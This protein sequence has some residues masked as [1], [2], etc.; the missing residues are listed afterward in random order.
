MIITP[1][2]NSIKSKLLNSDKLLFICGLS[3]L[4][5]LIVFQYIFV[6]S[7]ISDN[8]IV[9]HETQI[10]FMNN[11][12]VPTL[13]MYIFGALI[14]ICGVSSIFY[15]WKKN[16][17]YS[18]KTAN[19]ICNIYYTLKA[20]ISVTL[21]D[22]HSKKILILFSVCYFL[23]SLFLNNTIIVQPT[24]SSQN[25]ETM[26]HPFLSIIGCCG[27]P[28][29]FPIIIVHLTEKIGFNII[30]LNI[31]IPLLYSILLSITIATTISYRHLKKLR[32]TDKNN[33]SKI[34]STSGIGIISGF[35]MSCPTCAA[36]VI[37]SSILGTG[38]LTSLSILFYNYQLVLLICNFSL[39]IGLLYFLTRR[40]YILLIDNDLK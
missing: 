24:L 28:G 35:F 14:M 15:R 31:I 6:S 13:F 22:V 4:V 18:D 12:A 23:I 1:R 19:L 32:K 29:T 39:V 34:Y 38:I 16:K 37:L 2:L 8:R 21:Q 33:Y 10:K 40:Q 3:L 27:T 5:L 17:I 25:H 20:G 11:I 36:N 26:S 9:L 30:P 7:F